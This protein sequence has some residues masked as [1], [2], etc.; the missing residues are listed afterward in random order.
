MGGGLVRPFLAHALDV[1][2]FTVKKIKADS[3]VIEVTEAG[4]SLSVQILVPK[5]KDGRIYSVAERE[6]LARMKALNL[7]LDFAEALVDAEANT[8]SAT[9]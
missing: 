4:A 3:F 6:K 1:M 7:A 2:G 8:G 5:S 9:Q